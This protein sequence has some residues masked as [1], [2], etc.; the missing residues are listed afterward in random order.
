[1]FVM[2]FLSFV[3]TVLDIWN[4]TRPKPSY[5]ERFASKSGFTR[6]EERVVKL[7]STITQRVE[8]VLKEVNEKLD[9]LRDEQTKQTA[10]VNAELQDIQRAL[11]R[12]EGAAAK[13]RAS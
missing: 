9:D 11:G 3:K 7:E 6:L 2:T 8:G 5:D 12:L 13:G 4:G 10:T 1:M